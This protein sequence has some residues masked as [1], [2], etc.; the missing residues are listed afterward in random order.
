MRNLTNLQQPQSHMVDHAYTVKSIMVTLLLGHIGIINPQR[1]LQIDQ[2][3]NL[4][5]K[6]V[7]LLLG[8]I[9]MLIP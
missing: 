9:G 1:L 7:T 2:S 4:V 8:H 5:Y 6:M 3:D